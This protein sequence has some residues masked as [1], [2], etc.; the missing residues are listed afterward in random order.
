MQLRMMQ[1]RMMQGR[2]M[3]GRMHGWMHDWMQP[4]VRAVSCAPPVPMSEETFW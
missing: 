3:Q 1:L 4:V 2:M